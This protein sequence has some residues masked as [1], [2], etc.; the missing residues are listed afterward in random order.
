M[1][2]V[3]MNTDVDDN[4]RESRDPLASH[5]SISMETNENASITDDLN[6]DELQD[7]NLTPKNNAD[8]NKEHRRNNDAKTY[9]KKSPAKKLIEKGN[10]DEFKVPN[11][12]KR[13]RPKSPGNSPEIET[14]NSL[15]VL[16]KE[17]KI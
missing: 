6:M 7:L 12:K 4:D 1:N 3:T 16:E 5:A 9:G 11:E 13:S 8:I 14:K 10:L 2:T 15:S 17:E